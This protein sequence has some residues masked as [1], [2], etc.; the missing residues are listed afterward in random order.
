M[1]DWRQIQA[2]IRKAKLSADP[3]TG[4][5]RIYERTHDGMAA[6]ELATVLEAAARNEEALNWYTRAWQRFRRDD[7]KQK[8]A[9]AIERLGGPPPQELPGAEMQTAAQ[10]ANERQYDAADG[11]ATGAAEPARFAGTAGAA[12]GEEPAGEG[13]ASES[14]ESADEGAEE[15]PADGTA[16]G[17]AGPGAGTNGEAPHESIKKRSRRGRRGG[18][19]HRRKREREAQMKAQGAA[20]GSGA[21]ASA[22]ADATEAGAQPEAA[23]AP[24]PERE[25]RR[26]RGDRSR[27][28]GRDRGGD[29][30]RGERGERE[31]REAGPPAAG[32][33]FDGVRVGSEFAAQSRAVDP[34][35]ASRM[36][37]LEAKL[38]RLMAS[39]AVSMEEADSAPAGP[40]VFV[41][42]DEDHTTYYYVEN[43]RTL[44][45]A[46]ANIARA[47]TMEGSL[48]EKFADHLGISE[49]NVG[50]YVK[51]HCVVRWLQMDE[52]ASRL[53]HF[54]I[55][56]LGP[57]LNE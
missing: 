55:A 17:A 26:D 27:E 20:A 16:A 30:D 46:I 23:S 7:W 54:A 53:A 10:R 51:E 3:A 56:V 52:D 37:K 11:G 47:R 40:G 38:R 5:T 50:K 18:R 9:E 8:S 28:R 12:N 41:L 57:V 29:R 35:L 13:F 32:E 14:E 21:S 44:R 36:A 45:I 22:A 25:P 24:S 4:L 19:R 39:P 34:G 33:P 15:Q 43:C 6:F 31:R 49:S 2:R 42:S 1:A 48:K